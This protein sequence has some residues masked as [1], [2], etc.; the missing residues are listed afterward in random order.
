MTVA[1]SCPALHDPMDCKAHQAPLSMGF[2]RQEYWGG[3]PFSSPG[4]L[5]DPGIKPRS[6]ALQADA[7]P[8][9][10]FFSGPNVNLSVISKIV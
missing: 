9:E 7:L 8:S 2:P 5:P 3:L 1:Q 6:P 10:M 4:D